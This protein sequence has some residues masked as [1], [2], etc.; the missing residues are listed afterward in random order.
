VKLG[1]MWLQEE[2]VDLARVMED[3]RVEKKKTRVERRRVLLGEKLWLERRSLVNIEPR[4]TDTMRAENILP[5]GRLAV[6]CLSTLAMV[7]GQRNRKRD[8]EDSTKACMEPSSKRD[9]EE[10]RHENPCW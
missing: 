3:K 1:T 10:Q 2:L 6:P 5:K 7:T 8:M 9:F 4:V